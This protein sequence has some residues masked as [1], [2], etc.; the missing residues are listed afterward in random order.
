MTEIQPHSIS[1]LACVVVRLLLCKYSEFL[2]LLV[3]R[4]LLLNCWI[5]AKPVLLDSSL[6]RGVFVPPSSLYHKV[7]TTI[8][9]WVVKML[10]M[11]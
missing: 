3:N 8:N 5:Y 7:D 10:L 9:S 2:L 4:Y 6:L 1:K 11:L